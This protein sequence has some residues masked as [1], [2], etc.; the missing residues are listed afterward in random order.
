MS[1]VMNPF[2]V[3]TVSCSDPASP[4]IIATIWSHAGSRVHVEFFHHVGREARGN[5]DHG[6]GISTSTCVPWSVS[7]SNLMVPFTRAARSRMPVMPTR[8]DFTLGSHPFPSSSTAST[9]AVSRR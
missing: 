5:P 2:H 9:R 3:Q 8:Q 4:V 1:H 6:R 7:L